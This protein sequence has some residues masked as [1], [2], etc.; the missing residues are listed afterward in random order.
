MIE[1]V[2]KE[3]KSI[4]QRWYFHVLLALLSVG[5]Y[6]MA[7]VMYYNTLG[8]AIAAFTIVPLIIIAGLWGVKAGIPAG[9]LLILLNNFLFGYMDQTGWNGIIRHDG[10]PGSIALLIIGIFVGYLADL[11]KR[12]HKELNARSETEIALRQSEQNFRN[13]FEKASEG[14][15]IAELE[16]GRFLM[17]NQAMCDLFGY[18]EQEM[19]S[20]TIHQLCSE[21]E[22][23]VQKKAYRNLYFGAEIIN[24]ERFYQRKNGS[25]LSILTSA[26]PITWYDTKAVYG[27]IR[28]ITVIAE[29]RNQIEMKNRE[30]MDFTHVVT[31][32]MRNPLTSLM[33]IFDFIQ[34]EEFTMTKEKREDMFSMA[35]QSLNYLYELIENLLQCTRLEEGTHQINLEGVDAKELVQ[36]VIKKLAVKLQTKGVSVYENINA[37]ISVDRKVLSHVFVNL[38]ENAISYMGEQEKPVIEVSSEVKNGSIEF[39]IRDNGIGIP[40]T[41]QDIVFKKFKRGSNTIGI[42]GTGLGLALVKAMIEAHGGKIWVNSREGQGT[43]FFFTVPRAI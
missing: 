3:R 35:K 8:G 24:Q 43:S 18:S 21:E 10:I 37:K 39:C 4:F 20:A 34:M 17:V 1:L 36:S 28:D 15:Y 11:R 23:A 12:L 38:I 16:T 33:T 9:I 6:C 26:H 32:D 19:K 25:R 29:Y 13:M 7:F 27:S 31:H 42:K 2:E 22:R 40:M 30:I 14:L 41:D 5:L